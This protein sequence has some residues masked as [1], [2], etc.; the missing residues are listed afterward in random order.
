VTVQRQML[1][2]SST[3]SD[4]LS[5]V[6]YRLARNSIIRNFR[7]GRLSA[8]DVCDAHPELMRAAIHI[9]DPS[10]EECPICEEGNVVLVSY[11][12]GSGLGASGHNVTSKAE[13]NKLARRTDEL[14]CYVVEVCPKCRWNHLARS[15]RLAGKR[16][17]QTAG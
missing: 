17:P 13:L 3:S 12:F 5:H 1:K 11:V 14:T 6:D 9:G 10:S 15:F 4:R 7:N 2:G 8:L 16:R